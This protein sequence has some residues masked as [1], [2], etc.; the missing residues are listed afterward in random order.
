MNFRTREKG[1]SVGSANFLKL[2]N[3]E[4]ASGMFMGDVHEFFVVWN[5]SER[6]SYPAEPGTPKSKFRFRINFVMK[7]NG[8]FVAKVFESGGPTYDMLEIL[9]N[10][11]GLDKTAV[12]IT[13]T[14]SGKDTKFHIMALSPKSQPSE[15]QK[16]AMREVPLH[17]L[18][19]GSPAQPNQNDNQD[20]DS[21]GDDLPF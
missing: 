12:K 8:A 1:N 9:H 3:N 19:N 18:G 13:K 16:K 10:E 17:D 14:G 21:D 15:A 2:G 5:E 11:Y 6:R 7:E 4:S 20:A